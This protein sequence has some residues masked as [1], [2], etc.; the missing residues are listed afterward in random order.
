LQDLGQLSR[1]DL[2]RYSI[3]YGS[4][5]RV[6]GASRRTANCQR[7]QGGSDVTMFVSSINLLKRTTAL[8]KF[9]PIHPKSRQGSRS[10]QTLHSH[11]E[12]QGFHLNRER[13]TASSRKA[14]KKRKT[15]S[16]T[17][18][19]MKWGLDILHLYSVE[20]NKQP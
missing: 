15:G 11:L 14:A 10:H 3:V 18:K 13:K 16:K 19:A 12:S 9:N 20:S 7:G 8:C 6:N 1:R 17:R 5:P 4:S 2:Q